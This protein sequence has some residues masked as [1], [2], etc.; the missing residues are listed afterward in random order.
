MRLWVDEEA[1]L[2]CEADVCLVNRGVFVAFAD[3]LL[4]SASLRLFVDSAGDA[5]TTGGF[6]LEVQV[7][8]LSFL[9]VNGADGFLSVPTV[10]CASRTAYRL[11]VL[12]RW[13]R[14]T[15]TG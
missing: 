1:C 8:T 3:A 2:D 10:S 14:T 6:F 9:E 7:E 13:L 12:L 15:R 4:F 5:A 11:L